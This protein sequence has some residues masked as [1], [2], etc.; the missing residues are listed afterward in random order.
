MKIALLF[1]MVTL[2]PGLAL[3]ANL[4]D[5]KPGVSA[6]V[7]VMEFVSGN[8]TH[9]KMALRESSIEALSEE[10][11]NLQDMG[12][13]D[14]KVLRRSCLLKIEKDKLVLYR[15]SDRWPSWSMQ[16]KN[17]AEDYLKRLQRLGFCS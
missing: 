7:P 11:G 1:S 2:F 14:E 9:S 6:G 16:E 12:V 15:E 10:L 4:C 13:C 3:S 8:V 17:R 5:L